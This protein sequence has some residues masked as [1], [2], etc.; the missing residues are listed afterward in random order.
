LNCRK[1]AARKD[2]P[3]L[4]PGSWSNGVSLSDAQ[5][6]AIADRRR[7]CVANSDELLALFWHE[8]P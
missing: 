2:K 5:A 4:A 3:V 6:K 7:R 8:N 1:R